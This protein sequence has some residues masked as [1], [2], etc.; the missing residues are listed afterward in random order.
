MFGFSAFAETPFTS[1][2][3]QGE[4]VYPDGLSAEGLLG[5]AT[6]S[7][8]GS[9]TLTGL[10]ATGYVGTVVATAAASVYPTGVY[11]TG[12]VNTVLVWGIIPTTQ[13]PGW[14]AV[15]DSETTTWTEIPT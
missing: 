5:T 9:V 13:T 7:A 8:D 14:V 3:G 6:V 1:L 4:F 2:F 15:D 12:Y 10:E 11:A